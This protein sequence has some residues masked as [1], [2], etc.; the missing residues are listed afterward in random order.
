MSCLIDIYYRTV[1]ELDVGLVRLRL[2]QLRF[3]FC[4]NTLTMWVVVVNPP[5]YYIVIVTY[6]HICICFDSVSEQSAGQ[7]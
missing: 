1:D 6:I 7:R 5:I 2:L 4:V 3:G